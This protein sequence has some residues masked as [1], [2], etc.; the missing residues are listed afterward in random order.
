[1]IGQCWLLQ[2]YFILKIATKN[3]AASCKPNYFY[4]RVFIII[5]FWSRLIIFIVTKSKRIKRRSYSNRNGVFWWMTSRCNKT[6]T[7]K[8][9]YGA[10]K[11]VLRCFFFCNIDCFWRRNLKMVIYLKTHWILKFLI[12]YVNLQPIMKTSKKSFHNF[13][14]LYPYYLLLCVSQ[15]VVFYRTKICCFEGHKYRSKCCRSN[16]QIYLIWQVDY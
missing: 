14:V 5:C 11:N 6:A 12:L 8:N 10:S 3:T 7:V 2:L 15:S 16:L 1:M 13:W 4:W 9:V